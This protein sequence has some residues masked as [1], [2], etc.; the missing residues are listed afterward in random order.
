MSELKLNQNNWLG[1]KNVAYGQETVYSNKKDRTTAGPVKR[2]NLACLSKRK[3]IV[4]S[5]KGLHFHQDQR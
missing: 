5:K 4:V 2:E 3:K 1:E